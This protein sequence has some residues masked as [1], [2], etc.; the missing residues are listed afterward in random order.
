M[1]KLVKC[2]SV[3]TTLQSPKFSPTLFCEY[4]YLTTTAEKFLYA[5][6]VRFDKK[7]KLVDSKLTFSTT[8]L[9]ALDFVVIKNL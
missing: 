8:I 5:F 7:E 6:I 4:T 9:S 3:K 1:H 2:I